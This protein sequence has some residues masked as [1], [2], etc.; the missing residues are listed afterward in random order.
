M[1][2]LEDLKREKERLKDKIVNVVEMEFDS[3]EERD[4]HQNKLSV[5][6][7]ELIE[8][9]NKIEKLQPMENGNFEVLS[10][11]SSHSSNVSDKKIFNSSENIYSPSAD[12]ISLENYLR[13]VTDKPQNQKEKQA[14]EN[15]VTS[16]GYT[17]PKKTAQQVIDKIRQKNAVINAGGRTVTLTSNETNYITV[18]QDPQ[19]VWH[20]ELVEESA[21]SASF[22]KVA[23]TPKTVMT[24]VE[25]SR[26]L[27]QDSNNAGEALSIALTNSLSDEI[28]NVTFNGSGGNEPE[29]MNSLVTQTETYS[30]S[31]SHAEF[32]KAN[33]TL[34]TNNVDEENISY[35]YSPSVWE[36][37]SLATDDNG[38][39]Q[40][41]PSTI[42]DLPKFTNSGV[43]SGKAYA[44]DFT[45]FLYGFRMN[46]SLEQY[47]GGTTAKKFGQLWLAVAR[48]D[49]AVLRPNAFVRIESS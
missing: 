3:D 35:I 19:A 38:R 28:L 25:V 2:N 34:Y 42:R 31:V 22:G 10:G 7:S 12:D 16:D 15:S 44:G 45:N 43:P 11:G 30:G 23:M 36:T 8:V 18:D 17:L 47:A 46:I 26:E 41:A 6:R 39:Y 24:N 4:Y 37:L 21:N 14:L 27:L 5:W 33:S 1:E 9:N 49:L 48:M 40:D 32:V 13:A 20:A 29:G